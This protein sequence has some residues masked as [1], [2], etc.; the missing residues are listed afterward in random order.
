MTNFNLQL[1]D[2]FGNTCLVKMDK[3]VYGMLQKFFLSIK[4]D[5][6]PNKILQALQDAYHSPKSYTNLKTLFTDLKA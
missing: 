3:S 1:L 6:K 5:T 2:T 4:K